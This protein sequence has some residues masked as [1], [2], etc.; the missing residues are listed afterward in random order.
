MVSGTVEIER[1]LITQAFL[2]SAFDGLEQTTVRHGIPNEYI[3]R[4]S[5]SLYYQ[6]TSRT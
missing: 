4:L 3:T 5:P 1:A 6:K 2:D